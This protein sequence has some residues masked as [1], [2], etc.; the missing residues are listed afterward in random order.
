L[1]VC[2]QVTAASPVLVLTETFLL[3]VVEAAEAD[4]LTTDEAATTP[5][6]ATAGAELDGV[7]D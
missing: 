6:E 7:D 5:D 3:G 1:Q 4:D 2:L